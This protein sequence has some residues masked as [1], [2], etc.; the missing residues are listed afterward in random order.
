MSPPYVVSN[1][2]YSTAPDPDVPPARCEMGGVIAAT[3]KELPRLLYLGDVPVECSLHGSALIY[4]LLQDYPPNRL[5]IVEGY[6]RSQHTKRLPGVSYDA[7]RVASDRLLFT[8]FGQWYAPWLSASSKRRAR[9]VTDKLGGFEPEAVLTVTHGYLWITA[10]E[11]A[12]RYGLPLHLILHDVWPSRPPR[13]PF[14]RMDE[15]RF[16]RVYRQAQSRL[17]VSP[18]MADAYRRRYGQKGEVLYPSRAIDAVKF[19]APPPRLQDTGRSLTFA[20]AGSLSVPDYCRQLR[21]LAEQLRPH[22][23]RLN[24]FGP[25]TA[26]QADAAGLTL[27]NIY[28]A[29][30]LDSS[31]LV[32]RLRGEADVLFI[33]MSFSPAD[34]SNMEISFPSKLTDCTS[35]GVPLLICGPDYC[36]AV[37]WARENPGAAEVVDRDDAGALAQAVQRLVSD[38]G[39]RATLGQRALDLG[40]HYFSHRAAV[41][42]FQSALTDER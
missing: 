34:R 13:W 1:E 27:S 11:F 37:R 19:S 14:A 32:Q 24:V 36:S 26:D 9:Y 28:L 31:E 25:I 33:P 18:F 15:G 7:L 2:D 38:P 22:G 42:A 23:A 12:S 21:I 16:A 10:A 17:C 41:K 8:R 3:A 35:I 6:V 40:E 29:G 5:R 39:Y 30:M 20:Y 4:R